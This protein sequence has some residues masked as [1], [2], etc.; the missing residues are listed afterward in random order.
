MRA[1]VMGAVGLGRCGARNV[2]AAVGTSGRASLGVRGW[3]EVVRGVG[4]GGPL[5]FG[6]GGHWAPRPALTPTQVGDAAGGATSSGDGFTPVRCLAFGNISILAGLFFPHGL[7][8]VI[9]L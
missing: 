6:V 9:F 2:R 7:S 4:N 1:G 8:S 5:E 3:R